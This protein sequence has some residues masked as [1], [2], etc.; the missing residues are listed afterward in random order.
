LLGGGYS[1]GY[2]EIPAKSDTHSE[3]TVLVYLD[4][5]CLNRPFDDQSQER[6]RLEAEAV[7]LILERCQAGEWQ[8]LGSEAVDYEISRIP[9]E[10]RR[11][12]V[13]LLASVARARQKVNR[14]VQ[15]RAQ[16]LERLGFKALDAL[17]IAC[18]EA[19][20]ARVLLTTDDRML[21][22]ARKIRGNL[23]VRVE[24]PVLWLMEVTTGGSAQNDASR[25][26]G[27][28]P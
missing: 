14:P 12:R 5:C 7:L 28:R 21:N 9:D 10:E 8:L 23:R 25:D 19:G 24:N 22:I 2:S 17:H 16:E 27:E 4:V 6:I 26:S 20:G 13:F 11:Y 1:A 15:V 18:A 3:E